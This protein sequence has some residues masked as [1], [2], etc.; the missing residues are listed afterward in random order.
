MTNG[1][2]DNINGPEYPVAGGTAKLD[3]IPPKKEEPKKEEPKKEE[4]KK[5]ES[6]EESNKIK[7]D[8]AKLGP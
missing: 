6:K 5:D 1:N 8:T 4:P 7:S 3:P 2:T